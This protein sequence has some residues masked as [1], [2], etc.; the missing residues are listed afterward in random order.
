[1]CTVTRCLPHRYLAAAAVAA[2]ALGVTELLGPGLDIGAAAGAAPW[3]AGT[4]SSTRHVGA[5]T[6]RS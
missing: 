1:V 2:K 3:T 6:D 4:W 5:D